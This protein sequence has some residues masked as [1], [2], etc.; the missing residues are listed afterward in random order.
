MGKVLT[1]DGLAGLDFFRDVGQSLFHLVDQDQ[2]QITRRQTRK[3]C[4]D[5][6]EFALDVLHMGGANSAL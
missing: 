4:V 3:R 1:S 5:G 6:I 2:T